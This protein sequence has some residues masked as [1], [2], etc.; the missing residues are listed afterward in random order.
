M[1][2]HPSNER[3]VGW[4]NVFHRTQMSFSLR[5]LLGQNVISERLSVLIAL[6]GFFEPLGRTATDFQFRHYN[7]PHSQRY[8]DAVF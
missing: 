4:R 5:R 7:T 8:F 2:H 1:A 6:P 3:D